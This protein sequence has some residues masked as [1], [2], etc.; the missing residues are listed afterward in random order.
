[1]SVRTIKLTE[2]L[3]VYSKDIQAAEIIMSVNYSLNPGMIEN[4]Y[5]RYGVEYADRIIKPK[6]WRKE[7]T[8]SARKTRL[9]SS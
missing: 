2:Q 9:K 5:T 4:I 1:M 8:P 6:S 3:A 7:K